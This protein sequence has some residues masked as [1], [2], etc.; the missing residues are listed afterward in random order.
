[1]YRVTFKCTLPVELYEALTSAAKLQ[2]RSLSS[3]ANEALENFLGL[4]P[5][6]GK[7]MPAPCAIALPQPT[8]TAEP[9]ANAWEELPA[10]DARNSYGSQLEEIL[11]LVEAEPTES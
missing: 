4:T 8:A 3:I 6:E 7:R 10:A 9:P 2:R 1:M 5:W 11:G